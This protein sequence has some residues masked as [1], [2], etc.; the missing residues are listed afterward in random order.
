MIFSFILCDDIKLETNYCNNKVFGKYLGKGYDI[1]MGYPLPDNEFRK[2]PGFKKVIFN[3]ENSIKVINEN[4][5]QRDEY[6]NFIEDI[7]DIE[8]LTMYN[9][10]MDDMNTN[11]SPFSGSTPYKTYFSNLE[12][13]KKKFLIA[14]NTCLFCYATYNLNESTQNMNKDF[15]QDSDSLPILPIGINKKQ[16]CPTELYLKDPNN[17]KCIKTIKP[18]IDFF[19]NYG[20]HI[21]TSAHFGGQTLNTLEVTLNNL[22]ILKLYKYKLYISNIPYLNIFD[23]SKLLEGIF[24]LE[25]TK[26]GKRNNGLVG[27]GQ[28]NKMVSKL[29]NNDENYLTEKITN[30][31]NEILN[32]MDKPD[33]TL[34]IRG[35]INSSDNWNEDGYK[36]WKNSLYN[37]MVPINL[38]LI[39]LSS[40]MRINKKSSY[41]IALLYYNNLYSTN[42]KNYYLSQDI[43]DIY[44]DGRYV[45]KS[46]KGS[47]TLTCPVGYIK[48][49]GFIFSYDPSEDDQENEKSSPSGSDKSRIKINPC[50]N[51]GEYDVSCSYVNKN[52]DILTFGWMYC[53]KH[54]LAVFETLNNSY[55]HKSNK[56]IKNNNNNNLEIKCSNG[57]SL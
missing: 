46:G 36:V 56:K 10:I 1:V 42:E 13:Q 50:E 5:C 14:Q 28:D 26:N 11:I 22:E 15:L 39:S 32:M 23:F 37:K 17:K 38:D 12:I 24:K 54:K 49:T 31:S 43:V 7:N 27:T 51:V 33:I 8:L 29:N 47:L 44:A 48:S 55:Y 35:G 57:N 9:T 25:N 19:K 20:T 2:D 4:S 41:N 34:D 45:T 52:D 40:F 18:W 16:N 6:F 30:K 53:V 3:T 21:L